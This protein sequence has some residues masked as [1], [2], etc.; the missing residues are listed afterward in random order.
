MRP[1][2]VIL[3]LAIVSAVLAVLYFFRQPRI[4]GNESRVVASPSAITRTNSARESEEHDTTSGAVS[5][6]DPQASNDAVD[7]RT[8]GGLQRYADSRNLPVDFYGMAIDQDSNVLSG[9]LIKAEVQHV[10]VVEELRQVGTRD[11]PLERT[12]GADGRFHLDGAMGDVFELTVQ[13]DG[14]DPEIPRHTYAAVGGSSDNPVIFKMWN[15]NINEHLIGGNKTFDITPDGRPHVIDLTQ[16]TIAESGPGDLKVWIQYTNQVV[17]GQL[18]DWAAGIEVINGGLLEEPNNSAM[19]SA[20]P[21]GYTNSFQ[22]QQQIKGGQSGEIGD[23]SFY[24]LL[25]NGQEYGRMDI[26]LYAPYGHLYPGLIHLSY[27]INPSGSRI[28]R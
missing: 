19:Y 20:P 16:G 26:N 15:I 2:V 22:L 1:R 24:L 5:S 9:V 23:R 17:Q 14:Y 10:I 28:L 21:D 4:A 25:K 3:I 27:A 7:L 12:T 8:P 11:V 6:S 18:Y 13:K